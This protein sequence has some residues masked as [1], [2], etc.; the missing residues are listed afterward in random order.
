L[1]FGALALIGAIEM[2]A[3]VISRWGLDGAFMRYYLDRDEGERRQRL[4]STILGFILGA[5]LVLFSVA[6]LVSG[7]LSRGLFDAAPQY[8]LALRLMLIN[9]F[10]I[11]L[12]FVPFHS[13]RMRNQAATYS[14][15]TFARSIGTVIFR[16]VLVIGLR[17]GVTGWYLA[18]LTVTLILMPLL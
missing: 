13:M 11:A 16:I 14:A 17:L 7:P 9:T 12:T 6:L 15:F 5:N 3:K 8:V 1:D 10:L 2:F 18:D 4:T